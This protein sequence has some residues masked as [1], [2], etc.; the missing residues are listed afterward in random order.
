MSQLNQE[1]LEKFKILS[2]DEKKK[3]ICD[4]ANKLFKKY[5]RFAL[6]L[7]KI[8]EDIVNDEYLL[9]VYESFLLGIDRWKYKKY[10][11]DIV[12][13]QNQ[14]DRLNKIYAK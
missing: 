8:E 11:K 5:S 14:K 9:E 1:K 13:L 4:I 6:I 2:L 10:N 7:Q 3:I 12:L